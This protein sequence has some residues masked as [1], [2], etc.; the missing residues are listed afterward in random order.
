LAK[1]RADCGAKLQLGTGKFAVSQRNFVYVR[2]LTL[3]GLINPRG[4]SEWLTRTSRIPTNS[5]RTIRVRV[6]AASSKA[7]AVSKSLASSSRVVAKVASMVV[8]KVVA[9]TAASSPIVTV[10]AGNTIASVR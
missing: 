6:K 4:E 9:S 2:Q 10:K 1:I 8:A 5:S 7:A 3:S